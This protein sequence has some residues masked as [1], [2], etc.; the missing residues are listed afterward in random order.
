MSPDKFFPTLPESRPTI[1]AYEYTNLQ[2]E[3]LLKSLAT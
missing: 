1:Y 3:G 2:Y